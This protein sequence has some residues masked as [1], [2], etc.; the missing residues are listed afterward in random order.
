MPA[1]GKLK[2]RIRFEGR[3][4][5]AAGDRTGDWAVIDA[6]RVSMAAAYTVLRGTEAV[7]GERLQGRQP[8]VITVRSCLAVRQIDTTWRAVDERT[9]MV[10]GIN[11]VNPY[12]TRD[13]I[14]FL[15]TAE[16]TNG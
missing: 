2:E 15:A 10:Y 13:F 11:A 1:A 6:D 7:M 3:Q 8:V 16:G 4:V 12:P 14:D 9:A 5:D